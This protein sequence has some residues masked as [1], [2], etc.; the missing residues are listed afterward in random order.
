MQTDASVAAGASPSASR[1]PVVKEGAL[2]TSGARPAKKKTGA[3]H[4]ELSSLLSGGASAA[5]MLPSLVRISSPL[6]D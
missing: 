2:K 5:D 6:G 3:A 4:R 1:G